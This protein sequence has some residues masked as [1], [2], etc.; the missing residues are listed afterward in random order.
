VDALSQD[1]AS[2]L[3][4]ASAVLSLIAVVLTIAL[5]VRQNSLLRRYRSLLTG[6]AGQDLETLLLAQDA[7]L[8]STQREVARLVQ[9]FE[10]LAAAA[11]LHVQRTAIVR[12]NAFPDTG[13]DLSFAIA[14]LDANNNGVVLS[15]LYSRSES[16]IYAKPIQNGK[17]T[18][19]LSDE[20]RDALARAM[21]QAA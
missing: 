2:I 19:A 14:L 20:E 8:Q 13:S 1:P 11:R 5:T 10:Q 12:F 15:S 4:L 3:A 7:S 9:Q 18:Y 21:G 17:S 6:N 16:R